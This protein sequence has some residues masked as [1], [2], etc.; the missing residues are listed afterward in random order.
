M[1]PGDTL[2]VSFGKNSVLILFSSFVRLSL[3]SYWLQLLTLIMHSTS[4]F[5]YAFK[6][7]KAHYVNKLSNSLIHPSDVLKTCCSL[8]FLLP[9]RHIYYLCPSVNNLYHSRENTLCEIQVF[10]F[11]NEL[12][13][14]SIWEISIL[15][16]DFFNAGHHDFNWSSFQPPA[17]SS[18]YQHC[19]TRSR[20]CLM[21]GN[22]ALPHVGIPLGPPWLVPFFDKITSPS[23]NK[24][25]GFL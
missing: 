12:S 8:S 15:R 24:L 22:I 20:S 16:S 13:L 11:N 2:I 10:T 7:A 17:D 21:I 18:A 1:S 5:N 14:G 19:L 25:A 4:E 6:A 23:K 9:I 3:I